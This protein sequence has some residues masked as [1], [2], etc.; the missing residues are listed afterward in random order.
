MK[1]DRLIS[2]VMVLLNSEKL[3]ATKLAKMFEVTPRTIYRDIETLEKA[4]IPIF[5][6]TGVEGGI[7]ILPEY[8]VD[9]S[10]FT[11][12]DIQT[13]LMGLNSVSTAISS[14][15][16]IGILNKVKNLLPKKQ[17]TK[18]NQITV[19]LTT[20]MGNKNL[21]SSIELIKQALMEDKIIK[22]SYHNNAGETSS[23]QV[24]PYQLVLKESHWYLNAYCLTKKDFRV[25]KV[26]RMSQLTLCSNTFIPR[27]FCPKNMDGA[28]WIK[29]KLITIK[30]L[31][32]YSLYERMMELCGEQRIKSAGEKQF[33]VDFPFVPDE[34][35]YNLLL[36]FGDKC[37][38]VAPKSIRKELIKRIERVSK[39]YQ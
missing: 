27:E 24:E 9:K 18:A 14:K 36:G 30:L 7:G 29:P 17:L 1:I 33:I 2:I 15:D 35:G 21:L 25:F 26:A 28:D 39:L 11:N 31:I 34:F 38:C 19:D 3:S 37:E 5:T 22:F 8:K 12:S 13:L 23:R 6:I 32:D 20:W 4:G 10:F 16:V